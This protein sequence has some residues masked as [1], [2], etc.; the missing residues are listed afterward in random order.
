MILLTLKSATQ[1]NVSGEEVLVKANTRR[2]GI[3]GMVFGRKS[4][5]TN[6]LPEEG[7]DA[8][9]MRTDSLKLAEMAADLLQMKW[10]TNLPP[11]EVQ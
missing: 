8:S 7:C 4:T 5:K 11:H 3:L 9:I 6:R 1:S 2:P 10:S